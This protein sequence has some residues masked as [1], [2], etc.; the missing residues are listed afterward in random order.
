MCSASH[1][2]REH[3]WHHKHISSDCVV[4]L[5]YARLRR[6]TQKHQ[7]YCGPYFSGY[8]PVA[9]VCLLALISGV[10]AMTF[11]ARPQSSN[12]DPTQPLLPSDSTPDTPDFASVAS[13]PSPEAP[14][15]HTSVNSL[16]AQPSTDT[17]LAYLAAA[18]NGI[19]GGSVVAPLQFAKRYDS[20]LS[21][22][23][24]VFSFAVRVD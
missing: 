7:Y 9:Q 1:W 23:D 24:Y 8:H 19:W 14:A 3:N 20:H 15:L 13:V 10:V 12:S 21:G 6:G 4:C 17:K 11:S 5:G 18:F 2:D 16:P 22:L